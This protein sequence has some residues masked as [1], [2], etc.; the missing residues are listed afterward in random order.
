MNLLSIW[1]DPVY[2]RIGTATALRDKMTEVAVALYDWDDGQYG[3][4]VL[5]K[6]MYCLRDEYREPF[7]KWLEKNDF[8]DFGIIN[9]ATDT[10]PE[11][12]SATAE[13][14]FYRYGG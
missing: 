1:T 2:R 6:T 5:L 8:T 3:D 12:C 13:I 11:I 9:E 14:H 4:D 7:E 10:T